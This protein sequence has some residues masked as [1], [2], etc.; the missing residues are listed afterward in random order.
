MNQLVDAICT[1]ALEVQELKDAVEQL[2]DRI[3]EAA[4]T[5]GDG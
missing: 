1:L 3:S 4:G 2:T 5:H